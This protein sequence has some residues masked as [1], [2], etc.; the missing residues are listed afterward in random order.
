MKTNNN[1]MF[2]ACTALLIFSGACQS[3][4]GSGAIIGAGGGALIGAGLGGPEGALIGAGA[5][6]LGGALIGAVLDE[7]DKD[8]I[9]QSTRKRYDRHEQLTVDDIIKLHNSGLSDEKIAGMI[10]YTKSTYWLTDNDIKK[11]KDAGLSGRLIEYM[12][13]S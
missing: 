6:A 7:Q 9:D 4:A 12:N 10:D 13:K 1:I 5:G 8:R 3:K 2:I 11:L